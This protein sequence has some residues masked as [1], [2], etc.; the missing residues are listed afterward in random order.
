M[1]EMIPLPDEN[2]LSEEDFAVLQSFEAKEDWE[3][4]HSLSR[5]AAIV[6]SMNQYEDDNPEDLLMFFAVEA[7]EDI[8]K[9]RHALSQLEQD[10]HIDLV[11][12]IT[13]QRAA[14]KIYGTAG[15]V[16]CYQM[17]TVAQYIEVI[18]EKITAE[19]LFPV[20]GINALSLALP[21]LE[22]TLQHLI[23]HGNEGAVA[24]TELEE[25]LRNLNIDLQEMLSSDREIVPP[26]M[27]LEHQAPPQALPTT[28]SHDLST[29]FVGIDARRF[30][31]LVHSSEQLAELRAPLENAHAQVLAIQQEM[32]TAQ[33]SL[34]QM[35]LILPTLLTHKIPV[36]TLEKHFSSSLVTRILNQ[37]TP[38]ST[39]VH[40]ATSDLSPANAT[41]TV[42]WD[43]LELERYNEKDVLIHALNEAITVV[44]ITSAR[45]DSALTSLSMK[46]QGYFEQV[47]TVRS[48]TLLLRL[49]SLQEF[50]SRLQ[51]EVMMSEMAQ[52]QQVQ[53]EF[54]GEDTEVD[55]DILAL[56][57][58]PLLQL[59]HTCIA[60][61]SPQQDAMQQPYRVWLH[62]NGVGNEITLEIGFSMTVSG[63]ALEAI[64]E[65]IQRLNG[66]TYYLQ[67][68]AAGGVSFYLR[69]PRAYGKAQCLLVRAGSQYLIVPFS[70]V[71]RV[72]DSKQEKL[73]ILYDLCELLG[74][75]AASTVQSSI[76]P[77]L[78]LPQAVSSHKVIGVS[79]DEI[80]SE[81]EPIVKPLIPYL[82]RPGLTGVAIDGKGH[83]L[84][85]VDLPELIRH[86]II[87]QPTSE[88]QVERPKILVADD[89]VSLRQSVIQTLRHDNYTVLEAR[90]GMVALEKLLEEENTP[91][92]FL[93]DIEMPNLNGYDLL[94]IMSL[95]PELANVKIVMLTSRSSEK[96]IQRARELGAHAYLTKPCSREVLLETIQT[97]LHR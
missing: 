18:A 93:L 54:A 65:P 64:R 12:F 46:Q 55:Q 43:E 37:A 63:G 42:P 83:V 1:D 79:V 76:Q 31:H 91:D 73:D 74:F 92:L 41:D 32:R 67:R 77:V 88:P 38:R 20:I 45:L 60:N 85:M 14:H 75:S 35:Q 15:A 8:A 72:V 69:F 84:L 29:P 27:L 82:Q 48:S 52:T 6:S 57:T 17:A 90:D 70:Q 7:S 24:L 86:P 25:A 13:V 11:R 89:S 10:E 26:S 95:Y 56:L 3:L 96:H 68:N 78:I 66:S 62:A 97:L 58:H 16:G 33:A 34:R 28:V 59:V 21:T 61:T 30:V 51:R 87:P 53:F 19:L 23:A 50:V 39:L 36:S 47:A 80:V 4:K 9:M 5:G 71:Q 40:R 2:E 94:S 22:Q 81:I 44:S 49:A